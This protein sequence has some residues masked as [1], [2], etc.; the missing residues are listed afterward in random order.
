MLDKMHALASVTAVAGFCFAFTVGGCSSSDPVGPSPVADGGAP[1]GK[2]PTPP[3]ADDDDDSPEEACGPKG[4][5]VTMAALDAELGW[6]PPVARQNACTADDLAAIK[7]VNQAKSYRD[8]VAGTSAACQACALSTTDSPTWAPIV[9]ADE[10]GTSGLINFGACFAAVD[11]PACGKARQYLEICLTKACSGCAAPA[12]R[13][14]CIQE[15]A[16]KQ[17]DDV[18]AETRMQCTNPE[19]DSR[20][21]SLFDGIE[22]LCRYEAPDGGN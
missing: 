13:Q 5:A 16:G 10:A 19:A 14:A 17:C 12:E 3:P 18:Y 1:D 7:A 21:Q 2:A 22:Y 8:F 15:A 20:C 9:I 6:K 11:K 4:E